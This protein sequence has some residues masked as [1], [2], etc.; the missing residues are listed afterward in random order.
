MS[1]EYITSKNLFSLICDTLCLIDQ[2]LMEHGTRVSYIL[3]RCLCCKGGYEEYELAD[4]MLLAL[5]HD[6]GAYK[7]EKITDERLFDRKNVMPHS[8]Y[9]YLFLKHLSHM[10]DTAKVILYHHLDTTQL[11]KSQYEYKDIAEYIRLAE[12]VD[13]TL[14]KTGNMAGTQK[15]TEPQ[16]MVS[17]SDI[18]SFEKT[19]EVKKPNPLLILMEPYVGT[20]YSRKAFEHLSEAID[21]YDMLN[22]INDGSYRQECA[23]MLE[24]VLFSDEE[25]EKYLQMIMYC[26]GLRNK[27]VVEDTISCISIA[28]VLGKYL[29]LSVVEQKELYYGALLH[30]LGMLSFPKEMLEKEDVF[31]KQ[32]KE[33]VKEHVEITRKLLKG[34]FSESIV[35]IACA[36]HERLDGSG[37]PDKKRGTE[38]KL[39]EEILQVADFVSALSR[40]RPYREAKDKIEIIGIL[41]NEVAK[42]RLQ[43]TVVDFLIINYD[44]IMNYAAKRAMTCQIMYQRMEAKYKEVYQK[45]KN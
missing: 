43:K 17:A 36:H 27:H 37:Y 15:N 44:S 25:K 14:S 29:N 32:E 3:Y 23:A 31:T 35:R 40:K 28:K 39:Q 38:M 16:P 45:F 6:V 10:D 5:L 4:F 9:G 30:D 12:D 7:T 33:Q 34:R 20:K 41:R 1:V 11:A 21:Q 24:Y 42:E 18:E 8:I 2:N 13:Q 22:K 26:T 19:E